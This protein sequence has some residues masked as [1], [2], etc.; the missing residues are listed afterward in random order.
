MKKV[1]AIVLAIVL[2]LSIGSVAFAEESPVGP[3]KVGPGEKMEG[4]CTV[5][6][7]GVPDGVKGSIGALPGEAVKATNEY[8][9]NNFDKETW[10]CIIIGD[11]K[12]FNADGSDYTGKATFK[13]YSSYIKAGD[14]IYALHYKNGGSIEKIKA[15][16]VGDGYFVFTAD[17]LSPFMYAGP[18]TSSGG[19][20]TPNVEGTTDTTDT[21]K[22]SP[23][24]GGEDMA[25]LWI[26]IAAAGIAV[27]GVAGR[28]ALKA[29][30]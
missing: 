2:C 10:R 4:G 24:T 16:E 5:E 1:L 26:L 30:K 21:T 15:S 7:S 13:V 17:S 25:M 23:K 28:K 20:G 12:L 11:I 18:K 6:F 22:K 9:A 8:F 27:A 14:E 19:G 29:G 3:V